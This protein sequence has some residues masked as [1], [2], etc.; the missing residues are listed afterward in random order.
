M[1]TTITTIKNISFSRTQSIKLFT[2]ILIL[3]FLIGIP[4][5]IS[6]NYYI[7]VATV[8]LLYVMY[9]SS[10]RFSLLTGQMNFAFASFVGI[11]SYVTA[12]LI[13]KMGL[14]FWLCLPL[15]GL[16]AALFAFLIDLPALRI[17]GAY[18]GLAM[19]GLTMVVYLVW[20]NVPQIFGG[21][22]G[23][24]PIPSPTIHLG[25]FNYVFHGKV[26]YYYLALILAAITV[27]IL[28]RLEK[29][30]LGLTL[31]GIV[32]AD[33]VAESIG[34]NLTK[35]KLLAMC[36]SCFFAGIAGAFFAVFQGQIVP[37]DFQIFAVTIYVILYIILGGIRSWIGPLIGTTILILVQQGLMSFQEYV[38]IILGLLFVLIMVFLPEGLIDIPL[39]IKNLA[40]R[41]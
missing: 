4:L 16:G 23:L 15:A 10:M 13:L 37:D 41:R 27:F 36:I 3:L 20:V 12:L 8:I 1:K 35:Y 32:E 24:Y 6:N 38:P 18:F 26:P 39:K 40:K 5:F 11:G 28:V 25:S 19:F 9:T 17:K 7:H 21:A 14:S 22:A 2:P 30:R 33:N 34:I 31:S 29:S